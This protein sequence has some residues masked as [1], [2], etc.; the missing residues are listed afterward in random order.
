MGDIELLNRANAFL[1]ELTSG[2]TTLNNWAA[3]AKLDTTKNENVFN[4]QSTSKINTNWINE[5]VINIVTKHRFETDL[6]AKKSETDDDKK[7]EQ[8]I[9]GIINSYVELK[10]TNM[11]FS[12][13]NYSKFC[14]V[15]SKG[16]RLATSKCFAYPAKNNDDSSL[17]SSLAKLIEN[18]PENKF[19]KI[20]LGDDGKLIP[21]VHAVYPDIE[22]DR[23]CFKK[24]ENEYD[25]LKLRKYPNADACK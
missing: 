7:R 20:F 14:K 18:K 21:L 8:I 23:D 3:G 19:R 4:P 16:K 10:L 13:D 12:G 15:D 22:I 6:K 1:D 9:N 24:T 11:Y 25:G 2:R 17:G 5:N